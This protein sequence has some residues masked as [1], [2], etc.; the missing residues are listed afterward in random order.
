MSCLWCGGI[1]IS[2]C[3][4][5]ISCGFS[6]SDTFNEVLLSAIFDPAKPT[7]AG[8]I[9]SESCL[10]ASFFSILSYLL[11]LSFVAQFFKM[12]LVLL[13]AEFPLF[14]NFFTI[15]RSKLFSKTHKPISFKIF[16]YSIVCTIAHCL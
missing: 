10:L 1:I 9:L 3:S 12:S 15:F 16:S 6:F 14:K 13:E 8:M 2:C 4:D 11:S 7:T 5:S